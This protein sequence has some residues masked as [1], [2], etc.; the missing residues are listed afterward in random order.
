MRHRD[1]LRG[2]VAA[3]AACLA[4][5]GCSAVT[6]E[7][8]A[9]EVPPSVDPSVTAA[10][11]AD[12][13]R[14]YEQRL[15]WRECPA[16]ELPEGVQAVGQECAT[17]EVPLDYDDPGGETIGLALARLQALGDSRGSLVVNPGGP[18]GSG[19]DYALAAPL[20]TTER[21]RTG[22]DVV[23]FDPRGVFRSAPVD[24]VSD[25]TYGELAAA[26]PSPDD[27]DEMRRLEELSAALADGCADDP[28]APHV[29]SLS[30]VR[31]MDVLRAALG[32]PELDYLGKSYGTVLGALYAELFP[33]R[34]GRMV[35]DGAVDL[36]PRPADDT[37]TALEQ[38]AGF[39]TALRSFVADCLEQEDCPLSGTVEEGIDQ[40]RAFLASLDA[41][42]LPVQDSDR[43][44]T[45]GLGVTSL[46]LPLYQ[47]DLWPA[48]R[49]TLGPG[50]AG[51]GTPLLFLNDVLNE[52]QED[53]TYRTNA[54]EAIFAVNCLDAP[55]DPEGLA[56]LDV[57]DFDRLAAELE[58]AAP[59]FGPQLAYGGLPCLSWP[60]ERVEW[61]EVDG[62][63][64]PPVVV[65]G[66][67]RDPAT[68]GVWAE[69]LAD[70]LDS[71]V[72]VTYDGDGHT[73]YAATGAGCVDAVLDEF[74]LEGTV[75]DDGT[76][77]VADYS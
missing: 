27:Q 40:V 25:E 2:A 18:G 4:L 1:T 61:P 33:D 73:A 67:T 63:G 14:F 31:D 42:P 70:Q 58:D 75:P 46:L 48:L 36:T 59:T 30:V 26:D 5:A 49:Q 34:V 19:V 64:A 54:G 9:E 23:G 74:W 62:D 28:V 72:L 56:D 20:V 77:C 15:E 35:L 55:T 8:D 50:F 13:G 43:E 17:L 57:A 29:D 60:F 71:G 44:L 69:R 53:G 68:P 45:Q 11:Q 66:T 39:E 51:D 22:Y 7:P 52:R 10:P 37:T 76:E 3:V 41:A 47:Y 12:L 32:E 65:V 21:L 38:G 16:R 24:C 6:G